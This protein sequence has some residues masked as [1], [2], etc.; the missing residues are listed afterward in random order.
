MRFT[1]RSLL[2]SA[3]IA[4]L[5]L[6]AASAAT[7]AARFELRDGDRVVFLGDTLIE[8]E[9]YHGW[10]ELMLSARSTDRRVTFRNLGWSADTPAGVSRTG[11]SPMQAARE[12][13]NEGWIQLQQQIQTS[14]SDLKTGGMTS[15]FD[16]PGFGGKIRRRRGA[17]G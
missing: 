8:R 15:K 16:S 7:P 5:A 10:I 3:L 4:F 11:L 14:L 13:A 2:H 12:P 9:Q 17:R 1:F 6:T